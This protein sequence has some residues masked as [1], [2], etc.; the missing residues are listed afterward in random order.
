[1][2]KPSGGVAALA[3]R[4]EAAGG[5]TPS[6]SK[7]SSPTTTIGKVQRSPSAAAVASAQNSPPT[8]SG[9]STPKMRNAGP[10]VDADSSAGEWAG[11]KGDS[12]EVSTSDTVTALITAS[13]PPTSALEPSV[14][15]ESL[16]EP[17]TTI[18]NPFSTEAMSRTEDLSAS[19][20]GLGQDSASIL[21][22]GQK[23]SPPALT[24]DT[25]A[26]LLQAAGAIVQI[27]PA[28]P[29]EDPIAPASVGT[30]S[31]Q[32]S[33][34]QSFQSATD[35]RRG[36]SSSSDNEAKLM[37]D[38]N[39][40]RDSNH[41]SI[42]NLGDDSLSEATGPNS[43]TSTVTP[44]S[45]EVLE[46]GTSRSR[47]QSQ[48][49]TMSPPP[50]ETQ[51]ESDPDTALLRARVEAQSAQL[52][53]D[54]KAWRASIDG[55]A[56]LRESFERKMQANA[57]SS[58]ANDAA[59]KRTTL[60]HV[61]LGPGAETETETLA[62][63]LED[64]TEKQDATTN[65]EDATTP[66]LPQ[67]E[68]STGN[69][70]HPDSSPNQSE[71]FTSVGVAPSATPPLPPLPVSDEPEAIHAIL[72]ELV[73]PDDEDEQ[74][75]ESVDWTFWGEIM[76]NYAEVAR[77]RPQELSRAI[78]RGIP[79]AL[80]GMM[81][82]LMSSSK[83]EEL[84][85]IYAFYLKQT[86]PHEK[87]IRKD[88][89]RTFPEQD[90]F[91]DGKGVGQEN[92]FNVI[93]AYSLYDEECGYC[94]GMQFV[95]GPLLL[96][97][98]DEEAF[99]TM[100]RLMKSYDL[101]GHY[102]PNMPSLQ[103]R[104]FQFDR[105]L[106]EFLPLI[107]KHLVRQGVKSSMYAAQW[108][109]TCDSYR[110]PL[111]LVYRILD[112]VFAEGIESLFR[113]SIALMQRNEE[114]LLSLDFEGAVHFLKDNLFEV[115]LREGS[116]AE[117][118]RA[119]KTSSSGPSAGSATASKYRT[120]QFVADAYEVRITPHQLDGYAHEFED[121]V[122]KAN[123]HRREVDA[124]RLVNRNLAAKVKELETQLNQISNEHVDLVKQVVMS[125]LEKDEIAEE[126]ARYKLMYAEVFL[127]VDQ[128]SG[129][130]RGS[131]MGLTSFG[132]AG[133]SSTR[134]SRSGGG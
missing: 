95:V 50:G 118:P 106:E 32:A 40:V 107:H 126:L 31:S 33:R 100:A 94:Q 10:S 66:T 121:H 22:D 102:I 67:K 65:V 27:E 17:G 3:K 81:W 18:L 78:R 104:L 69:G 16:I 112:S 124:L 34:R 53:R 20:V 46:K 36:L 83:D 6:S 105:L 28:S 71:T 96:N 41:F 74:D 24:V 56:K 84:E 113:F 13:S 72:P 70:N 51:D 48:H 59:Y 8:T 82:Q 23:S 9:A 5:A 88:L 62:A 37:R 1:M 123:A 61:S 97:M 29:A 103:L 2:S 38:D 90:Y 85:I 76:S 64:A 93:K 12:V 127:Q 114:K 44:P 92:L 111:E 109:M 132:S 110:F 98:P 133:G 134:T 120:S 42:V 58:P 45:N 63:E 60:R 130:G 115:Y 116:Q 54:P 122:R 68:R 21:V 7:P 117:A 80:R 73:E 15:A 43:S 77:T 108:F 52:E 91:A 4:W 99:S 79:S 101:R 57:G 25:K 26:D 125:K 128:E 86:S 30:A 87:A 75:E 19:S 39:T 49:F 14:G 129:G 89:S 11:N 55:A 119:P 35:M 47:P 131:S